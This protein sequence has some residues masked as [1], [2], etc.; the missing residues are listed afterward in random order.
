MSNGLVGERA[1]AC[2]CRAPCRDAISPSPESSPTS[3]SRA[4]Y[5]RPGSLE[6]V[7]EVAR[8][9]AD[10]EHRRRRRGRRSADSVADRVVG[11]R[12]VEDVGLG[13]LHPERAEEPDGA[14]QRGSPGRRSGR[15]LR[16]HAATVVDGGSGV[17]ASAEHDIRITLL[18]TVAATSVAP[19]HRTSNCEDPV[20]LIVQIPCLNE[21]Q[22][23]PAVLESIPPDAGHRRDQGPRHRRR[24]ARTA[25]WRWPASTASPSS[26]TTPA[27]RAL[28]ARS[29]TG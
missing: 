25:P 23:L 18:I 21:E 2:R 22:T 8:S 13:L 3:A 26:S 24:V 28:V 9:P 29:G 12:A 19:A 16:R 15:G 5:V 1:A 11:E 20:K 17:L 27:P 6:G 7:A 14:A 10:V 4:K